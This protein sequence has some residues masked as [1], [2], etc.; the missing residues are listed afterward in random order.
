[1]AFIKFILRD[2]GDHF[3]V[4]SSPCRP[5]KGDKLQTKEAVSYK[6]LQ[7]RV[8]NTDANNDLQLS[9]H[10]HRQLYAECSRGSSK[11]GGLSVLT[12]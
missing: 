1:M 11:V 5:H 3:K 9:C 6:S 4:V 7:S 2:L 8:T 10:S 12:Q